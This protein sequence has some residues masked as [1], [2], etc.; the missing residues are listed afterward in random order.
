[1]K[2]I[3]LLIALVFCAGFQANANTITIDLDA[4]EVNVGSVINVSLLADFTEP[5]DIFEFYFN[6]D[7]ELFSFVSGSLSTDIIYDGFS[8]MFEFG[9]N[10]DG[11]GLAYLSLAGDFLLGSFELASFSLQALKAGSSD[12][13]LDTAVLQAFGDD[14]QLAPVLSPSAHVPAP[15]T[16]VMFILAVLILAGMRRK[17]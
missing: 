6:Y 9:E 12:F 8:T 11:L 1:M 5:V 3:K 7:T 10:T 16:L 15:A 13:T 14:L 2:C 17:A 4:T